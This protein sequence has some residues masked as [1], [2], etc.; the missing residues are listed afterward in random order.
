MKKILTPI[1]CCA[2]LIGML[3]GCVEET[4]EAPEASFSYT[5][6]NMY[7]DTTITFTDSSTDDGTISS[8]L[9]DFGDGTTSTEQ[10]PTHSYSEAAT[11]TVE[12]TVTDDGDLNDTTSETLTITLK[13]IVTT[14]IDAGFSTLATALEA[15][16]LVTTLQGEGPFTVFAP[17]DDAFAAVNQTWLTA[18]LE[19]T[20]NLTKVLTY[21]VIGDTVM[22]ADITD[23]LEKVT[24]EGTNLTFAVDT[25]G[26]VTINGEA[27]VT[28][29]DIE[30]N[31]GYIHVIDT[32]LI[33]ETVTGPEE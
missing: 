6:E 21:H 23:E 5:A 7:V 27:T 33:P 2:L 10:N 14:A 12:L 13:D 9:W 15:A 22:A 1:V 16:E 17:T 19:D 30:C 26:N 11:Y 24:L 18:L 28:Q 4:N 31:N 8:W 20:T 29:T 32:V 3:S 25:G